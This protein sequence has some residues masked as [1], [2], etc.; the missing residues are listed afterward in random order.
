MGS[1]VRG[2]LLGQKEMG[3]QFKKNKKIHLFSLTRIK[4]NHP[5]WLLELHLIPKWGNP[6]QPP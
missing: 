4:P 5:K 3:H 1:K 6:T 2:M